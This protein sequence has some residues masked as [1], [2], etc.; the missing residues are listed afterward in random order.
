MHMALLRVRD[1]PISAL[2]RPVQAEPPDSCWDR[3]I[4][5]S[6][7]CHMHNIPCPSPLTINI[8][9][10]TSIL[11]LVYMY[12]SVYRVIC[13]YSETKEDRTREPRSL[14]AQFVKPGLSFIL[15]YR[16]TGTIHHKFCPWYCVHLCLLWGDHNA[17]LSLFHFHVYGE[18]NSVPVGW[19][20]G[21]RCVGFKRRIRRDCPQRGVTCA[22]VC[23][24]ISQGKQVRGTFIWTWW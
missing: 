24:L 6:E 4:P 18:T 14:T 13:S 11:P 5:H 9:C 2:V 17:Y 3:P 22:S 16:S 10:W 19:S 21:D 20:R 12:P 15:S 1:G 23:C 8:E 7:Q